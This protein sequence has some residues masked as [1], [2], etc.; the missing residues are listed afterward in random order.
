MQLVRQSI[1]AVYE[2]IACHADLLADLSRISP[3]EISGVMPL[4][5][6]P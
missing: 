3:A 6:R 5:K 1:P 2:V 4:R